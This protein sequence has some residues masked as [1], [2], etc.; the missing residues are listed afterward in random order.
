M[1]DA[2]I[3]GNHLTKVYGTATGPLVALADVS[4]AIEE[5]EFISLVGPSGCGKSTLLSILGGLEE[6]SEGDVALDGE[7]LDR[8]R[9]DIGMMFQT[10]V[11]FPWRTV[12]Q[13]VRL[14][15]IVLGLDAKEQ[16][17][18]CEEL[19]D[20][21]GLNGFGDRYPSELSGGMRQRVALA[22]LL[23]HGPRVLLMDE[24][25]GA[26]DEFTRE[27]MNLE[28][29]RIWEKTGKTVVFVTHNI[30]ESVF[31]SDRVFVMTPR[32]GRLAGTIDVDLP[33]PRSAQMM[34]D[35]RYSEL[36]FEIRGMLGI[37][38]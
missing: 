30:G 13:N 5:G 1:T 2:L 37:D 32:P 35:P 4:F 25:F 12:R 38:H 14:P 28:L 15:G 17:Q 3:E 10:S 9:T 27:T 34:R 7:D 8:P 20:L 22:R 26:L 21:V 11:L 6:R 16:A 31:L 33:R 19:L 18:K 29:L 23:A 24:P 36:V